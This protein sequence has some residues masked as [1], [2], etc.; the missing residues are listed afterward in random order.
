MSG[1]SCR[2]RTA[3]LVSAG[4]KKALHAEG[5]VIPDGRQAS[6]TVIGR[7]TA[8][9]QP[10]G[11]P[12][13][14]KN[15]LRRVR[16]GRK[17][18]LFS[19]GRSPF[20]RCPFRLCPA[21]GLGRSGCRIFFPA[22]GVAAAGVVEV[23]FQ[24]GHDGEA[25]DEGAGELQVVQIQ[26]AAAHGQAFG[27]DALQK[28]DL[29]LADAG[30]AVVGIG[31]ELGT[32]AFARGIG[33]EVAG[34]VFQDAQHL[35][36]IV[37]QRA[38]VGAV[39]VGD[40]VGGHAQH[41]A[42]FVAQFLHAVEDAVVDMPR[43]VVQIVATAAQGHAVVG[44][45][46]ARDVFEKVHGFVLAAVQ[47]LLVLGLEGGEALAHQAHGGID[48]F[49]HR[50]ADIGADAVLVGVVG[51][52]VEA[53]LFLLLAEEVGAHQADHG[54]QHEDD[55]HHAAALE[56]GPGDQ[57]AGAEGAHG[58]QE[59]AADDGQHAGDAV[60]GALTVPGAVGEGGA[61]GHHEG[62]IGGGQG[63]LE[64]R[65]RGDE[66][67][68]DHQIDGRTHLVEGQHGRAL[69]LLHGPHAAFEG[70]EER[71]GQ[72]LVQG[73]A[74]AQARAHDEA[75]GQGR[76]ELFLVAAGAAAQVDGGLHHAVGL[77]GE[78]QG[79]HHDQAGEQQVEGG[80]LHG[81]AQALHGEGIGGHA[82]GGELLPAF[83]GGQGH[84][85]EVDQVVAGK[86]EGQGKGTGQDDDLENV[87]AAAHHEQ[88][89]HHAQAR[90][91]HQQDGQGVGIDPGQVFRLHEGRAL[92][93][94]HDQEVEDGRQGQAAED[95]ADA[96]VHALIVEG[97]DQAG[98]VLHHHTGHE[99]H[100]HGDEDAGHDGQGLLAVDEV[101]QLGEQDVRGG[102]LDEGRG[103]GT[104]QQLEDDGHG[105]GGGQAHGVEGVQ[106]QDVGDHHGEEND[107]DLVEGEHLGIE[108]PVAGDLHHAAGKGGA[109]QHTDAGHHHDDLEAGDARA[110]GRV[111]EVD[112]VIADAHEKVHCGQD[113]QKY[114]Y[115]Q[116]DAFHVPSP[117]E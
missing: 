6:G 117:A 102:D 46:G 75:A 89:Q 16:T 74:G 19:C 110:Y 98:D 103:H 38:A 100:H 37:A 97:E 99:G 1:K 24:Q 72:D 36:Q 52:D 7:G 84:A 93:A 90:E 91:Q 63:Q 5:F 54:H 26:V 61:H 30:R 78:P 87:D 106:Q 56:Q 116:K 83:P 9:L 33:P 113:G 39:A 94:F 15:A 92:G 71:M 23:A 27:V 58:G 17:G 10:G 95:A 112:G 73:L 109:Q 12:S 41:R 45:A 114:Q 53:A 31:R 51:H 20:R 47:D 70:G 13:C 66:D 86:G 48:A 43:L 29:D 14:L 60:D 3:D 96:A 111:E 64:G 55:G 88:V 101:P 40:V 42:Q 82:A 69:D 115:E 77:F 34:G 108:D 85:H 81:L 4:H 57:G 104:A 18:P 80:R 68:G 50:G 107:D 21:S 49:I 11:M 76:A 8:C 44:T 25:V 105:G 65:G 35:C 79:Q 67:A 2:W 62:H 22:G 59:P 32:G 28:L